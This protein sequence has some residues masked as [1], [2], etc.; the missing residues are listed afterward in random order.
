[1]TTWNF[2]DED[3]EIISNA[4]KNHGGKDIE[5]Y[6]DIISMCLICADKLDFISSR[7]DLSRLSDDSLKIFPYILDTYLDYTNN[8]I[9]LNIVITGNFDL[10]IFNSSSYYNKLNKFLELLSNKLN[11]NYK[12]QYQYK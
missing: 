2:N 6:K 5:N 1:M 11:S 3:I 4:I 7:Y 10:D 9:I 8:E 12:I